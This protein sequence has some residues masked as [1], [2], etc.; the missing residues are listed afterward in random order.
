MNKQIKT[1]LWFGLGY[2]ALGI[3]QIYRGEYYSKSY[4]TGM[5]FG[6]CGAGGAN[7]W[8]Y[9]YWRQHGL[10]YEAHLRRAEIESKDEMLVLLR[11]QAG[12][13]T[14]LLTMLLLVAAMLVCTGCVCFELWLPYTK[15]G[16]YWT[17]AAVIFEYV[18]GIIIFKWIKNRY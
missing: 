11:R 10:V 2:L 17:L 12:H 13:L 15:Y 9:F 4:A 16:L 1:H 3:A 6:F 8:R 18:C 5:G 7:L 14:Y